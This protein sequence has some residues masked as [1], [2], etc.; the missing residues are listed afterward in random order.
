M[1]NK[2]QW[3]E[4]EGDLGC[5]LAVLGWG[6]FFWPLCSRASAPPRSPAPVQP[7][8]ARVSRAPVPAPAAAPAAYMRPFL[9][10]PR[11][12]PARGGRRARRRGGGGVGASV[13]AAP[14]RAAVCPGA[15]ARGCAAAGC[16]CQKK[17]P[18]PVPAGPKY[19][20]NGPRAFVLPPP[21]S[22]G[23]YLSLFFTFWA[24]R[25]SS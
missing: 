9:P 5:G 23:A 8:R 12:A 7:L 14:V 15:C 6:A 13:A 24:R 11:A 21:P 17:R 22:I 4:G 18:P 1:T 16:S 2:P 3:K 20:P 10:P 25:L 19:R